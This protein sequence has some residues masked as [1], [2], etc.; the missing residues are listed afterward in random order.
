MNNPMHNLA[1]VITEKFIL[2][3]ASKAAKALENLATHEIILL[4]GS[5]K[6]HTIVM[7]LDKMGP[8]KAAAVLRRL[9]LKQASYV[10]NHLEVPQAVKLWKE[11]STP[12]QE[13]LRTVLDKSFVEL[14]TQSDRY[15][16]GS[17]A[18]LLNTDFVAVSTETK[19]NLLIE[20]LKNL[21]RK[22]LPLDC[23]LTGKAGELK[24]MIRTAEIAFFGKEAVCGSVMTITETLHL[25]DKTETAYEVFARLGADVLP[26]VNEKGILMGFVEERQLPRKEK[27]FWKRLTK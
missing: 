13:R 1:T 21:P 27:S 19:I 9:P 26:V 7:C 12:Y 15:P 4:I 25:T 24:G 2:A 18:Q 14:L 3:D 5:L 11:F 6:A 17:M 20:R 23:F 16:A 10:L 8:A 22:K